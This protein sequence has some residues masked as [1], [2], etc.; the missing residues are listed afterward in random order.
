MAEHLAA[1]AG[2]LT[3]CRT[4]T[5]RRPRPREDGGEHRFRWAPPTLDVGR[6]RAFGKRASRPAKS[7]DGAGLT[8]GRGNRELVK[9]PSLSVR[10]MG[11]TTHAVSCSEYPMGSDP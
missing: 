9:W 10:A 2:R 6:R 1:T 11:W 4:R 5:Q 3:T 8:F 7:G